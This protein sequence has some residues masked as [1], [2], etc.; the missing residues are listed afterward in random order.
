[1][2]GLVRYRGDATHPPNP[3]NYTKVAGGSH[4]QPGIPLD[5][6]RF[7]VVAQARE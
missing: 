7:A 4:A 6:F 3:G 2:G 1:M 5:M